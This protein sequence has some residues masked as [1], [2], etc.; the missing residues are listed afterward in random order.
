MT[1]GAWG[2]MRS[3]REG[4]RGGQACGECGCV[5]GGGVCVGGS[6]CWGVKASVKGVGQGNVKCWVEGR[7]LVGVQ[8][9]RR[10]SRC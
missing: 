3:K 9:G 1:V 4:E 5:R 8:S 7:G 10:E 6:A 2:W